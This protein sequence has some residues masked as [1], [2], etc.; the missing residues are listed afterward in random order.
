MGS[1]SLS[2]RLG[3]SAAPT[4]PR[5]GGRSCG[6][7]LRRNAR[8]C[9]HRPGLSTGDGSRSA[10]ARHRAASF[11]AWLS[12]SPTSTVPTCVGTFSMDAADAGSTPHWPNMRSSRS[13]RASSSTPLD[14]SI[15]ERALRRRSSRPAPAR[16]SLDSPPPTCTDVPRRPTCRRIYTFPTTAQYAAAK[17]WS[18]IRAAVSPRTPTRSMASGCLLSTVLSPICSAPCRGIGGPATRW[19]SSTRPSGGRGTLT[20]R[21]GS[22]SANASTGGRTLA[23][24]YVRAVCWIS[25]PNGP[26]HRPRAGCASAWSR[27]TCRYPRSTGSSPLRPVERS[28]ASTSPGRACVSVSSTTGGRVTP[29]AQPLTR[30]GLRI[31][32]GTA[33][34]SCVPM[35]TICAILTASSR[36]SVAR[37]PIAATH[38]EHRRPAFCADS[39]S[40]LG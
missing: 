1:V 31:C 37:S 9:P 36:A 35:R 16:S 21:C 20:T 3:Q 32:A 11:A 17:A 12:C 22:R 28:I 34:L 29:T 23:A 24:R 39:P 7:N 19:P 4:S 2:S 14:S 18:S 15:H 8:D 25:V 10:E 26:S 33:G 38:G 6:I 27:T 30:T 5:V 13:G 40:R